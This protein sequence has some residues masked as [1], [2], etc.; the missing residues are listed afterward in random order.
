[1]KYKTFEGKKFLVDTKGLFLKNDEGEMIEAEETAT[2]FVEPTADDTAEIEIENAKAVLRSISIEETTKAL[3]G[4]DF[5]KIPADIAKAIGSQLVEGAK[6]GKSVAFTKEIGDTVKKLSSDEVVKGLAGARGQVGNSYEFMAKELSELNSLT[7]ELP[8][9][10]R[11]PGITGIAKRDPFILDLVN[12]ETTT[13]KTV[14]WVEVLN[15][16]GAP[17]TTAELDALPEK[18]YTFQV[19]N[20][21]VYKVGVISKMSNEV[22]EDLPQL[23]SKVQNE[24]STDLKLK[25]DEKLLNAT[26]VN[27]VTGI[28]T[29]AP[30]FSAGSLAGTIAT[31]NVFD[32]LRVAIAQVRIAGKGKF[33]ANAICLNPADVT[34]MDL[35]KGTDGHYILPPFTSAEN[36]V[37]K[38]VKVIENDNITPGEFLVGD[39]TRFH[40][41][42]R[43]G[44]SLQ[45]ATENKDDFEKDMITVRLTTRL[46]SYVKANENGAFSYGDFATA[47]TALAI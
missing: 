22:L 38:G 5:S 13:S 27:D 11:Q 28:L 47:I 45:V 10:D 25:V 29:V 16:T 35:A 6:A 41:A 46:A 15:E 34:A 3:K 9:E 12:P 18:D 40:V 19:M 17:A 2:A 4:L 23:V 33:R 42:V 31:P 21:T 7:G 8:E 26:G 24:L 1:M 37:I 20:A 36:M 32:V 43:R 39:F 30:A 14:S 44:I